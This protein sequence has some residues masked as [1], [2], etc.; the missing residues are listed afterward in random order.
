MIHP[1]GLVDTLPEIPQ[2][3]LLFSVNLCPKYMCV[4][5][6]SHYL[7]FEVC[8][9]PIA[10]HTH[11]CIAIQWTLS[12]GCVHRRTGRGGGG[13]LT[14]QFG[15]IYD[16]YSGKRQHICLTNCVTPNG[17]SIHLPEIHFGW[18]NKG[19]VHRV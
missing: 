13:Q 12:E 4:F 16:I 15:Q 2:M 14:P 1:I 11:P 6:C 3:S 7:P 18:V 9:F 10:R 19:D 17:T 8:E 5:S